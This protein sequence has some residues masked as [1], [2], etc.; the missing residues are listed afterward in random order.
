M[1]SSSIGKNPHDFF[2]SM[3]QVFLKIVV[4]KGAHVIN[5]SIEKSPHNISDSMHQVYLKTLV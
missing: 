5:S 1:I 2:D 3:H 4:Q